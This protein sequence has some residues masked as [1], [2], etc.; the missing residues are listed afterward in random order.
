MAIEPPSDF[1]SVGIFEYPAYEINTL[2]DSEDKIAVL[3]EKEVTSFQA[4]FAPQGSVAGSVAS[5][6]EDPVELVYRAEGASEG[7]STS[8]SSEREDAISSAALETGSIDLA[9]A[10]NS[11][12]Q[13]GF[14]TARTL[15]GRAV[16]LDVRANDHDPDGDGM[17]F[18]AITGPGHGSI[19]IDGSGQLI[20]TPATNFVGTDQ[21]S[22]R[23][24][25]GIANSGY[26]SVTVTVEA[27]PPVD[28][29]GTSGDDVL[30]GRAVGVNV[31]NGLGG[32]DRIEVTEQN[33]FGILFGEA[34]DDRLAGGLWQSDQLYG[35]AGNDTLIGRWGDDRLFGEDGNDILRG[36]AHDDHLEGGSGDDRLEGGYDSDVLMGGAGADQLNGGPGDDVLDGGHRNRY[37]HV[38]T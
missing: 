2:G 15:S 11:A 31:I 3:F 9:P 29:F 22:Y 14:D 1:D 34:G 24:T 20:Y 35:G 32:D 17:R 25:D 4:L 38:R 16:S 27:N 8:P 18:S 30:N 28:L 12:P 6:S 19:Q 7:G 13:V 26:A 36:E 5:R 21:F 33:A 37:G 23:L 10:G